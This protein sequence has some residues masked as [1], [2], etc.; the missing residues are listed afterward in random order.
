MKNGYLGVSIIVIV[1]I[2]PVTGDILAVA[3]AA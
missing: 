1:M 3:E 2:A